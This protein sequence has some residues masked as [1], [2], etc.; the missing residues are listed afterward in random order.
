MPQVIQLKR[1]TTGA[2]VPVTLAPGELAYNTTGHTLVVG[3]ASSTVQPLVGATRQVEMTG[4]QGPINGVK[5]FGGAATDGLVVP[6]ATL[7][8]PGG[9]PGEV[10]SA[11]DAAGNLDFVPMVSASQ[12]FAGSAKGDDGSVQ[13]TTALGGATVLPAAAPANNGWY[14][15]Y[16]VAG[17]VKPPNSG[18]TVVGPF[19]IGDWLISNGT[20]WTHLQ[21]GGISSVTAADVGVVAPVTGGT[22][23]QAVLE[24]MQ[25]TDATFVVGP[26]ASV[27]DN[28]ALFDGITGL[29]IKDSATK[30]TDLATKAYV[31][32]ENTTQN[33][34][35][36]TRD[37]A[38]DVLIAANTAFVA[39]QPGVD[40]AQDTA[41]NNK[42]T[43]PLA[44]AAVGNIATFA[45]TGG[46]AALDGGVTIAQLQADIAAGGDVIGPALAVD[47]NIAV[48]NGTTGKII[49]DGGTTIAALTASV[50]AK[51]DVYGP[52]GATADNFA[53]FDTAT[54]KLIKDSTHSYASS[55]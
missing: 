22:N 45:D 31:D 54:G 33:T 7:M 38:Q 12:Q 34:T 49:E 4:D 50:A 55:P 1:K 10:L 20:A 21:Y 35:Q 13:L 51:G 39:A 8:I 28:I 30:L 41:I 52:A 15:I 16:D 19:E 5:T 24:T 29:L 48:Y 43:K 47:L 18:A 11:I 26:L 9:A 37:D 42:I 2:G 40:S 44:V 3:D 6:L 36:D 32:G 53:A 25:A 46:L 17:A 14:V 27:A 23:V